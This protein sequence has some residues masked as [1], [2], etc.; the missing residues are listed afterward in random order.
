MEINNHSN[1]S[2]QAKVGPKLLNEV[3][4][5]FGG[6]QP[7]VDKFTDLFEKVYSNL[8]DN[9]TVIDINRDKRYI[10]SHIAFPD[11]LCELRESIL[12][13]KSLP[14]AII[15]ECPKIFGYGEKILFQQITAKLAD[16]MSLDKLEMLAKSKVLT[17]KNQNEFLEI[18]NTAKRIKVEKPNSKLTNL[19]F[20]IM[21]N[22]IFQEKLDTLAKKSFGVKD[23]ISALTPDK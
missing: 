20:E 18:I 11:I 7:S 3:S 9:N 1:I 8:L 21:E 6:C 13:Y 23:L 10:M 5:E 14:E 19:E 22:K 15:T 16:K 12:P 17:P 2:F 4:K